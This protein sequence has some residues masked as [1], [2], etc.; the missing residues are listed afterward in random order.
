MKDGLSLRPGLRKWYKNGCGAEA[1]KWR[2][3]FVKTSIAAEMH[4]ILWSA[5]FS[6]SGE[7]Q[8]RSHSLCFCKIWS[9]W[10][11]KTIIVAL[12]CKT[13]QIETH[14]DAFW[15]QYKS[16]TGQGLQIWGEIE[17]QLANI[18]GAFRNLILK[19]YKLIC[20][21]KKFCASRK[22]IDFK[23]TNSIHMYT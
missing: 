7:D 23:Y 5:S 22:S 20:K 16:Y 17:R 19:I 13:R 11:L 15:T 21:F 6:L 12:L 10:P 2:T 8:T 3:D 4:R 14:F 1:R 18:M 9:L